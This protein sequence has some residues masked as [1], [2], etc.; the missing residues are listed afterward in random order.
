MYKATGFMKESNAKVVDRY[1]EGSFQRVS[2]K[3]G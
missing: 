1:P 3:S 2:L